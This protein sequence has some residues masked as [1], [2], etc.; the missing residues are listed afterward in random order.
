MRAK[1]IIGIDTMFSGK[2]KHKLVSLKKSVPLALAAIFMSLQAVQ[3]VATFLIISVFIDRM[4]R[5]EID[6][7]AVQFKV[8]MEREQ[9]GFERL[10]QSYAEWID[11]YDFIGDPGNGNAGDYYTEA[12]QRRQEVDLVLIVGRDGQVLWT[13]DAAL[14]GSDGSR[15]GPLAKRRFSRED[16]TAF[17]EAFGSYPLMPTGGTVMIGTDPAVI[18]AW[19][20]SDDAARLAPNGMLIFARIL[21]RERQETFLPGGTSRI[22]F[23]E[24]G[25]HSPATNSGSVPDSAVT[26]GIP[27]TDPNGRSIG[28]WVIM[29]R[30]IIRSATW[31][32][33][34]SIMLLAAAVTVIVY[35]LSLRLV[36]QVAIAPV[37][38]IRDHLDYYTQHLSVAA[39][40]E[41]FEGDNEIDRLA[42]HVNILLSRVTAQAATLDALA[43]TDGLTGL[44]NRRKLDDVIRKIRS[45]FSRQS[46]ERRSRDSVSPW[47]ASA[48]IDVDFFKKY[49]DRYG[50]QAGDN[51]L[52]LVAGAIAKSVCRSGDLVCR[53][54]GEE[55]VLMLP[56][57]DLDGAVIVAERVREKVESLGIPHEDSQASRFVTVSVG[58]SA[59]RPAAGFDPEEM[60][61]TADKALYEAKAGGRNRVAALAHEDGAAETPE[62][63]TTA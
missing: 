61:K 39:R 3:I 49:N 22:A 7:K 63:G 4:E 9:K 21:G 50:H 28:A 52:R 42:H 60:L 31:E 10:V 45:N 40:L 12:W 20:V 19:P 5:R 56:E 46:G 35:F 30:S 57:T 8:L 2:K 25:G 27:I 23:V 47:I 16:R 29:M 14:G 26:G 38:K 62:P 33:A 43:A 24:D 58:I 54:G 53:Y 55:F 44:P 6:D 41:T 11:T 18:A 36:T 32:L 1:W 13:S 17:P 15:P 37:Q 59:S 48:I 51:A 34:A